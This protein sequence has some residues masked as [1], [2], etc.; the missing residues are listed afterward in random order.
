M[1]DYDN[2]LQPGL[3]FGNYR[4]MRL[5]GRGGMGEVYEVEHELTGDRHAMKLL[6]AEVMEVRGALVRISD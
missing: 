4:I 6:S 3:M 5:L 2:S 1:S